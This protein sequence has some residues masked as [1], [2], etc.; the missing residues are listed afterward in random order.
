MI[1]CKHKTKK[2]GTFVLYLRH[3][4]NKV[5]RNVKK[6]THCSFLRIGKTIIHKSLKKSF[7]KL[8][9]TK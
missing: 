8:L 6:G 5:T 4:L 2:K 9:K 1:V 3:H 7:S